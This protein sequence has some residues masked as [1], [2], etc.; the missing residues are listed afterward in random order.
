M[1]TR[2][3]NQAVALRILSRINGNQFVSLEQ[4]AVFISLIMT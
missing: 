2:P 4:E 1:E 3:L